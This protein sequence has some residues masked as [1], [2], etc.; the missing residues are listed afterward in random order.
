VA[1]Q[2]LS[3]T[4][5]DDEEQPLRLGFNAHFKNAA[6]LHPVTHMKSKYFSDVARISAKIGKV[7]KGGV[8][9]SV[10]RVVAETAGK[11]CGNEGCVLQ[12]NA[13]GTLFA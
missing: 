9:G 11:V 3:L 12:A 4:D 7:S 6:D 5:P 13:W 10:R 1:I 8:V 2:I